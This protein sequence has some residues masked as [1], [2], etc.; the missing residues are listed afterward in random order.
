MSL[1]AFKMQLIWLLKEIKEK[2]KN[3]ANIPTDNRKEKLL[4]TK[5]PPMQNKR[6]KH[7]VINNK[8]R[9]LIKKVI[10]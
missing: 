7:Q 1:T 2:I 8:P 9:Y 6:M 10:R 4:Q 3:L 5:W